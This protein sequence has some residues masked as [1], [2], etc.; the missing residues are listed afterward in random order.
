MSSV[1]QTAPRF[2]TDQAG[3]SSDMM[4]DYP[5]AVVTRDGTSVLL[6][7]VVRSDEQALRTF[8]AS[9]PEEEQ[10]F[11]RENLSD[12]EL[13]HQWLEAL[14]YDYILPIVAVREDDGT[15]VANLR[16]YRSK[17]ESIRHLAH[18]RVMVLPRYR[19]LK[20]GSWMIL[21]CVKLAMD[22][23]IEKLIAE[24]VAGVEE[25]AIAAAKKLDFHQEA[26][27]KDYVKD[28]QGQD[29]DL[30]IMVRNLFRD[31]SDF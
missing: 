2:S 27:L 7:P 12:P 23:G 30:I 31:W 5:K 10:W 18:L 1:R 13:L 14:D 21:D 8:F 19:D 26:V 25:G 24:F 6:R 20:V 29:R 15:I 3:R 16:L 4:Q 9:I 17:S 11:L 28:R 22:L